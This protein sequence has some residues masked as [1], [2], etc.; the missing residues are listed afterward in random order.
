MII[1]KK[2]TKKLILFIAVFLVLTGYFYLNKR[3]VVIAK[4]VDYQCKPITNE[5]VVVAWDLGTFPLGWPVS[6]IEKFKTDDNGFFKSKAKGRS[7]AIKK[8]IQDLHY[9]RNFRFDRWGFVSGN[10]T[11]DIINELKRSTYNSP[12]YVYVGNNL[13]AGIKH[14]YDSDLIRIRFSD[15][16]AQM[17]PASFDSTPGNIINLSWKMEN[18]IPYFWVTGIGD[19]GVLDITNNTDQLNRIPTSNYTKSLKYQ[20]KDSRTQRIFIIKGKAS[21]SYSIFSIDLV[22]DKA[23]GVAYLATLF[24]TIAVDMYSSDSKKTTDI[25]YPIIPQEGCGGVFARSHN[26]YFGLLDNEKLTYLKASARELPFEIKKTNS[27]LHTIAAHPETPLDWYRNNIDNWHIAK[28]AL[29]NNGDIHER[30]EY[31]YRKSKDNNWQSVID[32]ISIDVR[33]SE[34]ILLDIVNYYDK[35]MPKVA[36]NPSSTIKVLDTILDKL[37]NELDTPISESGK[38][39]HIIQVLARKE[40]M[41]P[42][43]LEKAQDIFEKYISK[44]MARNNTISSIEISLIENK[45]AT[46]KMLNSTCTRAVNNELLDKHS[47]QSKNAWKAIA[48]HKNA[49]SKSLE[50]II[51]LFIS[52]EFSHSTYNILL[53]AIANKNLDR[54]YKKELYKIDNEY[55]NLIFSELEDTPLDIL[56]KLSEKENRIINRNLAK[57][58]ATPDTI[59]RKLAFRKPEYKNEYDTI[60]IEIAKNPSAPIDV[61]HELSNDAGLL[62]NMKYNPSIDDVIISK[63]KTQPYYKNYIA[64]INEKLNKIE[65]SGKITKRSGYNSLRTILKNSELS[66]NTILRIYNYRYNPITHLIAYHNNTPPKLLDKIFH[67]TEDISVIKALALNSNT[68]KDILENIIEGNFLITD[69]FYSKDKIEDHLYCNSNL[70]KKLRNQLPY[71]LHLDCERIKRKFT[72]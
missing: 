3:N 47:P 35:F 14:G 45:Q 28:A 50:F 57:N 60:K 48:K 63:L 65:S 16:T 31:I 8:D 12:F 23:L 18:G 41:P 44:N 40:N 37:N 4:L 7:I 70:P 53:A 29:N 67:E 56:I 21:Q 20:I 59:F 42:E 26:G 5:P 49:P 46:S 10:I 2:H 69:K 30:I 17:I 68:P 34:N 51:E 38:V 71:K 27:E 19:G 1:F 66:S 39:P 62:S 32:T 54:S 22:Y 52:E 64:S 11:I 55:L 33:A 58:L 25:S 15:K 13:P 6:D 72:R 9:Y 61:L 43:L 24:N 36:S